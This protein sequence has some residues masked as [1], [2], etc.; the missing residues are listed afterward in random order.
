M[1]SRQGQPWS[2]TH[3][4]SGGSSNPPLTRVSQHYLK[5]ILSVFMTPILI[6]RLFFLSPKDQTARS[7]QCLSI[8]CL[9]PQPPLCSRKA[10]LHRNMLSFCYP[11]IPSTP[12]LHKLFQVA[13]PQHHNCQQVSSV[14]ATLPFVSVFHKNPFV[15]QSSS[16]ALFFNV[17]S[18]DPQPRSLYNINGKVPFSQQGQLCSSSERGINK[19]SL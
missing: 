12:L 18:L 5:G 19:M 2:C 14:L 16:C 9:C 4:T 15:W 10:G 7:Q 17:S 1:T 6:R 13:F 11:F 8:T 3:I